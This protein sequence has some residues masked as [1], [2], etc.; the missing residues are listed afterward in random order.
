MEARKKEW[1]TFQLAN[2]STLNNS[3]HQLHHAAQFIA[4]LGN[5]LLPNV[6]DD[7]NTNMCWSDEIGGLAGRLLPLNIP[8]RLAL[9]YDAFELRFV[10]K[11][12]RT[13]S[14]LHLEGQKKREINDWIRETVTELGGRAEELRPI[15]H[16]QLPHH[17]TESGAPF[18]K[19]STLELQ[20]LARYRHN[21][22]LILEEMSSQFEN[23]APVRVWPHHFDTASLL[24]VGF[25][26]T[27]EMVQSVGIGL[28][29]PDDYYDELYFYVN[30][31]SAAGDELDY[32]ELP[33]LPEGG[34]WHRKDWVGAVLKASEL[35]LAEK[36]SGQYE[37]AWRFLRAGIN[38]SLRLLGEGQ[39]AI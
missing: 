25:D 3:I 16:Y 26:E 13:F 30:H 24:P 21:A 9:V 7:S 39:M 31:W 11:Q 38:E 10:D 34:R 12:Y 2:P 14:G 32:E 28:A 20:E 4:L 15:H 29:I 35:N 33:E 27:G 19:T 8:V 22:R 37:K 36:G 18:R 1:Q 17:P 6:G 23:A 5:S